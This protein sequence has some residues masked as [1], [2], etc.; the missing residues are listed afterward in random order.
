VL[1]AVHGLEA[2]VCGDSTLLMSFDS[3]YLAV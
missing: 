1:P 2:A 3:K